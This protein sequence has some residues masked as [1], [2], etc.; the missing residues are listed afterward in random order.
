MPR[1]VA[2]LSIILAFTSLSFFTSAQ[3]LPTEP[4]NDTW[5][6]SYHLTTQQI[7]SANLSAHLADAVA[8]ALNFERTN[9]AGGP[10]S[11]DPFYTSLPAPNSSN[12]AP[13][14]LLRVEPYTNTS[15]YTLPPGVALSRFIYMTRTSN[16]TI[17]PAS[18]YILWPFTPRT[19]PY[20]SNS[21]TSKPES[22]PIVV[23]AHGYSG[24]SASCA[25]SS[26][27]VLHQDFQ[28]PFTLALQGYVV[29]APDFSGLGGLTAG[30]GHGDDLLFA[31]PAARAAF[32][33]ELRNSSFVLMGHSTGSKASWGAASNLALLSAQSQN[34]SQ[35]AQELQMVSKGYLG[36]IAVSPWQPPYLQLPLSEEAK[37]PNALSI[38][39]SVNIAGDLR[40][41]NGDNFNISTFLNDQALAYYN[42]IY[43]L[44]G[45]I[46]T[47][48]TLL[49]LGEPIQDVFQD[50]WYAVPEYLRYAASIKNAGL[51]VMG[52]LLVL[53]ATGDPLS[54]A[55]IAQ[56]QVNETCGAFL[57]VDIEYVEYNITGHSDV[58][59]A[60]QTRW[61]K[62]IEDRFAGA[63]ADTAGSASGV[64]KGPGQGTGNGGSAGVGGCS[65]EWVQPGTSRPVEA[66]VQGGPRF[67]LEYA[68]EGYQLA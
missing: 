5:N 29:V 49:F 30:A 9:R 22:L 63:A 48:Q 39:T 55:T 31:V 45:C 6:S 40:A 56:Q 2:V 57:D 60:A 24:E 20:S 64:V 66:Y 36:T 21:S 38:Y 3:S 12:S 26:S 15:L 41:A 51:P 52:P 61:L 17:V 13:G 27:R 11:S 32:P 62:W 58:L 7:T 10:V 23:W 4:Q 46:A 54:N 33:G 42:L 37:I 59:F 50:G 8:L 67:I 34:D 1:S 19:F 25:P 35:S 53:Q 68:Q 65:W 43:E 47:H 16:D 14:S 18:A 28:A 44:G